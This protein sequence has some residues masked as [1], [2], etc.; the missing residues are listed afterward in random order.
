MEGTIPSWSW[1]S[2]DGVFEIRAARLNSPHKLLAKILDAQTDRGSD[3]FGHVPS[4]RIK[5]QGPVL[6]S[7]LEMST[8]SSDQSDVWWVNGLSKDA[9]KDGTAY[10]LVIVKWDAPMAATMAL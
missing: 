2:A 7:P 1:T 10:F 9:A 6:R 5:L 3:L 8:R 4:G